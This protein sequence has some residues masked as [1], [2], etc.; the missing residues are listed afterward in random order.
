[1]YS[2]RPSQPSSRKTILLWLGSR[3][4]RRSNAHPGK[5]RRA[6]CPR[7]HRV[8]GG[9]AV[10]GADLVAAPV[11]SRANVWFETRRHSGRGPQGIPLHRG[12][13]NLE[14]ARD[15]VIPLPWPVRSAAQLANTSRDTQKRGRTVR[16]IGA[17]PGRWSPRRRIQPGSAPSPAASRRWRARCQ[18][19]SGRGAN[20]T[21]GAGPSR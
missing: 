8:P 1:M 6:P 7:L 19:P 9:G 12:R 13:H 17:A 3:K 20:R 14:G 10:G 5:S 21:V 18:S 16:I 15:G 11:A 4:G 2:S